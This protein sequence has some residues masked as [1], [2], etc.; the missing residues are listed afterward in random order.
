[1]NNTIPFNPTANRTV[2]VFDLAGK[3]L[4]QT[5]T[6]ATEFDFSDLS[7]GVYLLR[8][9]EESSGKTEGAKLVIRK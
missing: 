4:R 3:L 6:A 5:T 2:R 9:Q 8:I 7:S 1:M